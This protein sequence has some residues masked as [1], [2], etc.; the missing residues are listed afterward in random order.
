[1]I[2]PLEVTIIGSGTGTPSLRR[3]SPAVGVVLSGK[4]YLF[5][6]GPGTLRKML[7]A[8]FTYLNVDALFFTHTH[9]D[10]VSDLGPFLFTC[11][12]E[13]KPRTEALLLGGPTGF[14]E[15]YSRLRALYGDQIDSDKYALAVEEFAASQKQFEEFR[16]IT[17]PLV[18]MVFC[19]GYRIETKSGKVLVYSGDTGYCENIVKLARGADLLILESALPQD[20]KLEGH[21]TPRE[22]GRIAKE[23]GVKRLILSHIY[24]ICERF[25][26][27]S[28]CAKEFKG[29]T[30]LAQDLLKIRV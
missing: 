21:L 20:Y 2:A 9:V 22:A 15:F 16:L 6:A 27:L 30:H 1:M 5:D 19:I 13:A 29:K 28:E 25:D 8:G 7:E 14:R 4:R 17:L 12:Y 24:P 3:A 18:H 23:A 10:H 11:K 26:I